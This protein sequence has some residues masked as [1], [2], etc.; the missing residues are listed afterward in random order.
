MLFQS[1]KIYNRNIFMYVSHYYTY[2]TI[3]NINDFRYV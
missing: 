2:V 3:A 1:E